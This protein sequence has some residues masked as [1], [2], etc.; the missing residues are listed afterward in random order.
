[1]PLIHVTQTQGKSAEEKAELLR[2]LTDTYVK[3]TGAKPASVWATVSE[4]ATDSWSVGGDTLAAR[5]AE[6]K[7]AQG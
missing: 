6:A 3:V 2:E 1:M 7:A 4:V 5:A